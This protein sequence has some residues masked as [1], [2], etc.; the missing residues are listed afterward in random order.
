MSYL[1]TGLMAAATRHFSGDTATRD[2]EKEA[3]ILAS[4][5]NSQEIVT[6]SENADDNNK[7]EFLSIVVNKAG[8]QH[9]HDDQNQCA[10]C[11]KDLC[12]LKK[13]ESQIACSS[14]GVWYCSKCCD[15]T[16]SQ[17]SGILARPDVFWSCKLC[18]TRATKPILEKPE[19]TSGKNTIEH[20]E[21]LLGKLEGVIEEKIDQSIQTAVPTAVKQCLENVDK[22]VSETVTQGVKQ[23]WSD[24][25]QTASE[26]MKEDVKKMMSDTLF[27]SDYPEIDPSISKNQA[28]KIAAGENSYA[29]VAAAAA[30]NNPPTLMGALKRVVRD[31]KMED[32]HK[33]NVRKNVI[34]Y[35]VPE[36]SEPD[37]QVRIKRDADLV[38]ELIAFTESQAKP[39][40]IF[41]VGKFEGTESATPKEPRPLKITFNDADEVADLV[42]KCTKLK[43]APVH[44]KYKVYYD[45]TKGEREIL[46]TMN[47]SAKEWSQKSPKWDWKVRGPPWHPDYQRYHKRT[48]ATQTG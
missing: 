2:K 41:R 27:G 42:G 10:S 43:D 37:H 32:L 39:M 4:N 34:I 36:K 38:N 8:N 6:S 21:Q 40:R 23:M 46:K 35:G 22:N 44:M 20:F 5:V 18:C 25:Q 13:T 19:S 16:K 47:E 48:G 24:T 17:I 9:D 45:T 12:K 29:N 7:Q 1:M 11:E 26:S 28:K 15:F 30:A 31:Q 33:V 3:A 14:C